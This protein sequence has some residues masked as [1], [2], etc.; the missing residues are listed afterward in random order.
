MIKIYRNTEAFFNA[1]TSTALSDAS[2]ARATSDILS[3]VRQSGD[4]AIKAL[5]QRF[6]SVKLTRLRVDAEEL[7][8]SAAELDESVKAMFLQAIANVRKFHGRQTRKDWQ[9]VQDGRMSGMQFKAIENV[10]IYVP[11][12][13]AA[14]PSTVIMTVVPA[15]LAGVPRIAIAS[16]P[17]LDGKANSFVLAV[18]DL[19]GVT[20][21]YSVG[22]AQAIAALAY[23]TESIK[24]VDKIVGPGNSFVNEAKRQVFGQV[25]IDA[26]AG[27]TELVVLAD[28]TAN[29][30]W[31][32]RDM[33]AQAEHDPETC[34]ICV[35]TSSEF[36]N[37]VAAAVERLLPE[38]A[39]R[40]ILEESIGKH[41]ALIIAED[42]EQAAE[43]VNR[44]A[45]E[46]LEIITTD[47]GSVLPGIRNAGAIFLGE[48]TPAVLGDYCGG[49][50][51][52]LPT[53]RSARFSSPLSVFD[54]LKFSSVFS[55]SA[56]A[57]KRNADLGAQ[58]AEL[59]GLINHQMAVT[60]R[61]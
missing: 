44:I 18:A 15:Q 53:G 11:G 14:Y 7:K 20:E 19:L 59:E 28:D 22:G 30:E 61:K 34:A 47:P 42:L 29:P 43:I 52:V 55:Y 9:E 32:A 1:E 4:A 58:F 48:N 12:G 26:L 57:F 51:H 23:G 35:T 37:S 50:N 24:C 2:V 3:Q 45:P 13:R 40:E 16:P 5:T 36:A 25:G 10:G 56:T 49:P 38:A 33:F 41:G 6:D 31:V 8:R 39:R 46:H 17:G 27:P 21:V 54:F 60:C